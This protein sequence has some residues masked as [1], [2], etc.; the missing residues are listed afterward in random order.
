MNFT[1]VAPVQKLLATLGALEQKGLEE[2]S[3]KR[4]EV[5]WLLSAAEIFRKFATELRDNG[6]ACDVAT[7]ADRLHLRACDLKKHEFVRQTKLPFGVTSA[8]FQQSNFGS[9]V[10]ANL[11]G[12]VEERS[13]FKGPFN[14][15]RAI[16]HWRIAL[17]YQ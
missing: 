1:T 7:M 17:K 2:I 8:A 6:T 9:K 3:R 10:P 14:L 16:D 4:Q 13:Y 11:V 15:H 12:T 5:E